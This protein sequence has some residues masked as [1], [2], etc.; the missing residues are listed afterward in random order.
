MSTSVSEW[1]DDH[2]TP[3]QLKQVHG[4]SL[5]DLQ[6]LVL[7]LLAVRAEGLRYV[8]ELEAKHADER[9]Q[10]N[11][12][13]S[14]NAL[15]LESLCK[16]QRVKATASAASPTPGASASTNGTD[17]NGSAPSPSTGSPPCSMCKILLRDAK[18]KSDASAET[19]R[20]IRQQNRQ[21]EDACQRLKM[22][23]FAPMEQ[24]AQLLQFQHQQLLAVVYKYIR[25]EISTTLQQEYRK[26]FERQIVDHQG[27]QRRQ[28]GQQLINGQVING[29]F[30]NGQ[31]INGQFV[32]HMNPGQMMMMPPQQQPGPPRAPSE[33]RMEVMRDLLNGT[34]AEAEE[35]DEVEEA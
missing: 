9:M 27:Q 10:T 1:I 4:K 14:Q 32:N 20:L 12:M 19:I 26:V 30:I 6:R 2:L 17:S 29:Q 22:Q 33:S 21:M 35:K 5:E 31:M 28:G 7:R 24:L 15:S 13:V 8:L 23:Y 18:E 16:D 3:E 25:G 11:R 34:G